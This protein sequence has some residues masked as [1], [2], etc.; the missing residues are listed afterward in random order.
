MWN[1]V[2]GYDT[3]Y[4][5]YGMEDVDWGFR[6][7]QAGFDIVVDPA[8][9]ATHLGAATT[10]EIRALRAF[11]SGAARRTFD[12]LHGPEVLHS[13]SQPSSPWGRATVV[14]GRHLTISGVSRLG[15]SVDRLATYLPSAVAEKAV[16]FTVEAAAESGHR[17]S[18]D[19]DLS[20]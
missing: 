1:V 7:H 10:T 4:R 6:L 14:A 5:A 19:L 11:H 18:S 20:I 2:G 12:M 9:D 13:P 8:L 3:A 17:H 16:A 15:R